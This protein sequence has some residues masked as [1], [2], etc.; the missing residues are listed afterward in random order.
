MAEK[1]MRIFPV[2]DEAQAKTQ[3]T[4]DGFDNFVSRLGLNND[5]ALSAGVYMFNLMTRNRIQLEAAY[6]GSWVVGKVIDCI[7]EDM[8]KAG[9]DIT[10][11]E[12]KED[13]K[14]LKT[15]ISR[16]QVWQSLCSLIK[17]GRLYGGAIGVLQI[18]GQDLSTPFDPST[19]SKGQFKGISV[20][21]RWMV[22]P[23]LFNVIKTGP[24]MGLPSKYQLVTS[25]A[26]SEGIATADTSGMVT[27]HHSRVI[28]N[29]GIEL[30]YFQAITEMM[31]GESILERLWDRLI[32]FDSATMSTA[33]LIERANN[34][35]IGIEGLREIVSS[36]GPAQAGLE[37]QFEMMRAFQTN[38][39]LTI[40]DKEDTFAT[41]SYS[42]AG[43]SDVLLQFGQQLAGAANTP[44]IRMF[45]QSP[46]GMSAT[47]ESD[48]RMY[49]DDINAQQESR[50]RPAWE[51]LLNVL[52]R[53][54][55][56]KEPPKDLEFEFTPLWQMS[57]ADKANIGKTQTETLSG[58]QEAGFI[59]RSTAMKELRQN[60]KE[61]GLFSNI[62]DEEIKEAEEEEAMEPPMPLDGESDDPLNAL[63]QTIPDP[64]ETVPSLDSKQ[65]LAKR[66]GSWLRKK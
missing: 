2:T 31:W 47:G 14:D 33:N 13:L 61:I 32:S 49:Y 64:S 20:F 7:A 59:K 57:T 56:G 24:D 12:S 66:I 28:R 36:G 4:I 21:D 43:L 37:A 46:A 44:L 58:A 10:T 11:N 25:P 30:P 39:G 54:T 42:F 48:I 60:S 41:T 40:M 1:V 29:I 18:E 5:N 15:Q 17:W 26:Q 19:V 65:P 34:R 53:S 8:T 51:K 52:W 50:L 6:R 62:S 27:V 23:D 9:L 63:Q 3:K 38:E 55:Y 22:N 35:T 45:G 16:R